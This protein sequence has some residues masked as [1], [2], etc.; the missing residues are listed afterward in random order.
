MLKA[1]FSSKLICINS[2]LGRVPVRVTLASEFLTVGMD[3]GWL[4]LSGPANYPMETV[5]INFKFMGEVDNRLHYHMR[6]DSPMGVQSMALSRNG[7]MGFYLESPLKSNFF[8]I[9]IVENNA[10]GPVFKL[11]NHEGVTVK[12]AYEDRCIFLGVEGKSRPL[13]FMF[14][15]FQPG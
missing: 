4:A 2:S 13:L 10:S 7:Y 6:R 5:R 9:E 1:D 15:N 11:R 3:A 8:K 14:S 12:E